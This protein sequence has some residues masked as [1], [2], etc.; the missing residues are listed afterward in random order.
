MAY[1]LQKRGLQVRRQ[2]AIPV[3]YEE[4][5]MDLGFRADLI[6][7]GKVVVEIKIC[8][9]NRSSTQEATAH[10]PSTYR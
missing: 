2:Q 3:V 1:E 9:G 7:E 6:V 5:R 4:V 8:G 10:L